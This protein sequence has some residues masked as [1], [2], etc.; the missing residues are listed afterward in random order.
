MSGKFDSAGN[1][2][3]RVSVNF[4]KMALRMDGPPGSDEGFGQALRSLPRHAPPPAPLEAILSRWHW[5]RR[6]AVAAVTVALAA[7]LL[8]AIALPREAPEPPRHLR[9]RIVDVVEPPPAKLRDL[10]GFVGPSEPADPNLAGEPEELRI[11]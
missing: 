9:I 8:L 2:S 11:P 4:E 1:P 10:D 7:G 6:R 5:R 3:P